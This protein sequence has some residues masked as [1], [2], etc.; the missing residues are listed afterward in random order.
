[1]AYTYGEGEIGVFM[2]AINLEK[3]KHRPQKFSRPA[4]A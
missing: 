2:P 4:Q 1:M 3:A